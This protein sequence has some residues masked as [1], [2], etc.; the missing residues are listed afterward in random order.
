MGFSS[1]ELPVWCCPLLLRTDT[2]VFRRV[3]GSLCTVLLVPLMN[4]E[5]FYDPSQREGLPFGSCR[6]GYI[7]SFRAYSSRSAAEAEEFSSGIEND[8]VLE[9]ILEQIKGLI[10]EYRTTAVQVGVELGESLIL[11]VLSALRHESRKHQLFF[12]IPNVSATERF[13][14]ESLFNDIRESQLKSLRSHDDKEVGRVAPG[15]WQE[16]SE[17]ISRSTAEEILLER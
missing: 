7:T 10:I 4:N 11:E 17:Y 15:H 9:E 2:I 13:L 14:A 1:S 6:E 3:G 8:R 16:C 12:D 5:P